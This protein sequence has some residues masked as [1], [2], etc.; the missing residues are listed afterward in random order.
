MPIEY[1]IGRKKPAPHGK[2]VWLRVCPVAELP[3][4]IELRALQQLDDRKHH[5]KREKRH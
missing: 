4:P 3:S 1:R 5:G 2:A